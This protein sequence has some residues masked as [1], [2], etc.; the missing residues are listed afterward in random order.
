MV[1]HM[2]DNAGD[3]DSELERES[4]EWLPSR[5]DRL[6]T[7][8]MGAAV[9]DPLGF[10]VPREQRSPIG[11]WAL[12]ADGFLH[13]A[14]RIVESWAGQPWEDELIY[15]V[16]ALYRQHLE[17]L[18]KL[19]IRSAPGFADD[20]KDWLYKTHEL[21]KLWDKLKEVYPESHSWASGECTE[22]CCEL[23]K[24]FSEHDPKS[25]AAR[26]PVD[27]QDRQTLQRLR[28]IDVH[29]FKQGVHKVSHYLGTIIESIHQD[30]EWRAE[31]A[32][33]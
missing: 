16:L 21:D 32:S 10:S 8:T 23:I 4:R 24:E 31:V 25:F 22:S 27:K 33:W 13:A 5:G 14:D 30:R 19:V 28:A 12:Y 7:E 11:R 26:Y 9:L 20:L 18:L 3:L 17:L 2:P 29:I 6:F 1:E 15:P